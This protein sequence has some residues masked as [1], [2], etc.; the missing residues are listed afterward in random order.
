M[1]E[2]K[3]EVQDLH[4]LFATRFSGMERQLMDLHALVEALISTR[5]AGYLAGLPRALYDSSMSGP[6][7]PAPSGLINAAHLPPLIIP[8]PS[9]ANG[10]SVRSHVIV[11]SRNSPDSRIMTTL[12]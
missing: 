2:L 1:S 6:L 3:K 10:P 5:H 12:I 7:R 4:A 9:R 11:I 8:P